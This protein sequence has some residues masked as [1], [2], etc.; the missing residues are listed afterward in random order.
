MATLTRE[1]LE[2]LALETVSADNYY[3]LADNIDSTTDYDLSRIIDC[4]GDYNL[5]LELE[6]GAA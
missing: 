3:D 2:K 1:D 6:E 4:G 5:E